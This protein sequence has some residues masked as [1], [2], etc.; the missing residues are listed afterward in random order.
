[1]S[2]TIT[3]KTKLR[4]GAEVPLF[5]LG[6]FQS[7]QGVSC[8]Q[9]VRWALD[10]GYRHIDTAAA[11]GN[12][13]SVGKALRDSGIPRDQIWVTTKVWNNDQGY[14]TTL[15]AC[16]ASLDRLGLEYLDLY[17]IH[18]PATEQRVDSF[19]A[20]IELQ[21]QGL[22]RS[23]GVSNYLETHIDEVIAA[24]GE[25]PAVNQIE[26]S[27]FLARRPLVDYCRSKGIVP[28]AYSPLTRGQRLNEESVVSIAD[29]HGKTPAQVLIRWCLEHEIVVI[30]KSVTKERIQQNA[31]VFDFTL[32]EDDMT[33][34]DMLDEDFFTIRPGVPPDKWD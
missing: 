8:E 18:W 4:D 15:D 25:V 34:L 5:G 21:K 29:K 33:V 10:A 11:Y 12:E 17:L 2:L 14:Q 23:I 26:L 28:E 24:T 6:T 30:P 32:D 13:D 19:K 1:M 3:S 31:D 16:H 20:M 22:C 7:D 27:P 9:A